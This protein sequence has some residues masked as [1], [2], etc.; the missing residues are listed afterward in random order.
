MSCCAGHCC[1]SLT[2]HLDRTTDCFSPLAAYMASSETAWVL[3]E[4]TSSSDQS[5]FSQ[6]LIWGVWCL[7]QWG[8]TFP[9]LRGEMITNVLHLTCD[10]QLHR[11]YVTSTTSSTA[12]SYPLIDRQ[13][14]ASPN[15]PLLYT[16]S[17][18]ECIHTDTAPPLSHP[19]Q[20]QTSEKPTTPSGGG[21]PWFREACSRFLQQH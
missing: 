8:N 11:T 5:C 12:C 17:T 13:D 19:E 10:A 18:L 3:S 9:A 1:S 15:C 4:E 2:L 7:W 6:I 20:I 21:I 14:A 16:K